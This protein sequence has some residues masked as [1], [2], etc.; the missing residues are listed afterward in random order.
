MAT[1]AQD[2]LAD[3]LF[4]A[5]AAEPAFVRHLVELGK[6]RVQ[7]WP[8]LELSNPSGEAY[9]RRAKEYYDAGASGL[10]NWDAERKAQRLSEWAVVKRLGH[11]EALLGADGQDAAHRA[12]MILAQNV[13]RT[14]SRGW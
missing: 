9:A 8:S 4:P 7:V 1:W 14:T 5:K 13:S 6:G 10:M 12:R 11:R 2:G 3:Y